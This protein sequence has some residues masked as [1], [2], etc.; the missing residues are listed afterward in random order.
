MVK[1]F[2][3]ADDLTGAL[4]TGVK[5]SNKGANVLVV[6]DANYN[7]EHAPNDVQ[8][9]V[10][11]TE[12][13]H[14]SAKEAYQRIYQLTRKALSMQIPYVYKKTDSALRGNIG[15]ELEA[16]AH[17]A[18]FYND[19]ATVHFAPSFPQMKR[20]VKEGQLYIN[21]V[22]VHESVFGKDPFE[23]VLQSR[24][25]DIIR[26]QATIEL[27]ISDRTASIAI[28]DATSDKDLEQIAHTIIGTKTPVLMA[29]SAGLADCLPELLEIENTPSWN[30]IHG[31]QFLVVCGSI[32]PITRLQ[33][34]Y[35]QQ[36]GFD[37]I[38]ISTEQKISKEHFKSEA[39]RAEL[40]HLTQ[41]VLTSPYC[42]LDT[43]DVVPG[44]TIKAI[45]EHGMNREELRLLISEKIGYI[46]RHLI[47]EGLR[48][49]L[50]I[51]GGD[52]LIA[53]IKQ[54]QIDEMV[55]LYELA[56][57]IVLSRCFIGTK[58]LYIVSKSGGFGNQDL[59]V[60]LAKE[61]TN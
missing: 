56:P 30:R 39:G 38:Q 40:E 26:Q 10:M 11:N 35:A 6:P 16:V 28:Y 37:R 34:D 48:S 61:L 55:P 49:I 42:L 14:A 54:M 45:H 41:I 29:G 13:R 31:Q 53:F 15:A 23:P 27:G 60:N 51:T 2:M 17:A 32:N 43:N 33:L 22:L 24:V 12:T 36:H 50:L 5:F 58:Q 21:D 1:L 44:E 59:F 57:G 9:L 25:A 47:K 19:K 46:V 8:I 52:T 4:D 18:S 20:I 3:M 7:L